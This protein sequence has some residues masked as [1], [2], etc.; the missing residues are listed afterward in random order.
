M[1]EALKV[2][3]LGEEKSKVLKR[4]TENTEAYQLYLQAR[5]QFFKLT[6][7]GIRRSIELF[8]AALEADPDYAPALAWLGHSYGTLVVFGGMPP[9]TGLP[10]MAAA[11]GRALKID[12][13]LDE[14]Q[15]A[16]AMA[17]MQ[18]ERDWATAERAFSRAIDLN[19]GHAN[20]RAQ[21][22]ILLA[23]LGRDAEAVEQAERALEIDPLGVVTN[24]DAGM[25]FWILEDFDRVSEIGDR[26][27][28]LDHNFFGGHM[29]RSIVDWEK[30]DL[31]KAIQNIEKAVPLGLPYGQAFPAC[32]YGIAGET[33]KAKAMLEMM[34]KPVPGRPVFAA[35]LAIVHAG[36][37]D[38]DAT[39]E[40]LEAA[41]ENGEAIPFTSLVRQLPGVAE[42]PRYHE[43]LERVGLPRRLREEC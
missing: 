17:K 43:M 10:R 25:T 38:L 11:I 24:L 26:V 12:E 42:D 30:G 36:L 18:G 22:G 2:R 28:D 8:E 39:F 5:H 16:F 19:P 4:Y 31:S 34:K 27:V 7:E 21:F 29:M 40:Y 37:G 41:M 35:S 23:S 13:D 32:L 9:E 20:A 33:E 6:P 14:A 15:F 3:L 1:V